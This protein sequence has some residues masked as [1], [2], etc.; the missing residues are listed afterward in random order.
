MVPV[1]LVLLVLSAGVAWSAA[2]FP[3]WTDEGYQA[4]LQTAGTASV[5][6]VIAQEEWATLQVKLPNGNF[7]L[8]PVEPNQEFGSKVPVYQD[9]DEWFLGP[10]TDDH[11]F[12]VGIGVALMLAALIIPGISGW[13]AIEEML[14][15]RIFRRSRPR[16][17]YD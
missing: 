3:R 11:G 10:P 6:Q 1:W 5:E 16:H 8:L 12:A 7:A 15:P 17:Y 4:A 2:Q 14:S 9:D 13:F